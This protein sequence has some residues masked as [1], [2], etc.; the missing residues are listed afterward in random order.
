MADFREALSDLTAF[1]EIVEDVLRTLAQ[2]ETWIEDARRDLASL[3]DGAARQALQLA[4][5]AGDNV[6]NV[7]Y[8]LLPD[9]TNHSRELTERIRG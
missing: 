3:D 8:G 7:R 2:A 4:G 6:R 9:Y 1:G 5:E